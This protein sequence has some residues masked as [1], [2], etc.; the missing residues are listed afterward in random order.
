MIWVFDLDNTLHDATPYIFPQ[1]NRGM[2]SYLEEH[3]CLGREEAD[4]LRRHY[5]ARYGATLQ[6]M[7]RH[8]GT[9]PQ[10]FLEQTHD[11]Q[12]LSALVVR[13]PGLRS[14]LRMIRGEKVVFTNA[15][16][17]YAREVLQILGIGDLFGAVYSIEHS[18][19]RPKPD[20]HG[21]RRIFRKAG[22]APSKAVMVE[23]TLENLKSAKSLGMKTVW[24]SSSG[25]RPS[26]VDLIVPSIRDLARR[27]YK[28]K[29]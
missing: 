10:H 29:K 13:S 8:H 1:I 17:S 21:F 22:I 4:R 27:Q 26:F 3:L 7:I 5:W 12:D 20:P 28:L 23:D 9:N 18:G 24:I 19:F 6:G 2:T 14:A 16:L 25:K 15:P 11:F